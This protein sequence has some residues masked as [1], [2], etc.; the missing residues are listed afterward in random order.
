MMEGKH[1]QENV[2]DDEVWPMS[3][4]EINGWHRYG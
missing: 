1:K 2:G 3:K 4:G